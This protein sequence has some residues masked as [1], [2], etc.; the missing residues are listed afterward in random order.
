M[1]TYAM[2]GGATGIGAELRRQLQEEGHRVISV[3]IV[4][5][6]IIADLATLEGRRAAVDGVRELAPDGLDGFIPCAGLPPVAKPLSSIARVN[7]F[8]VVAT[9]EGLR[10]LLAK[11][12]GMVLF[13]SSNSAPMVSTGDSY[14][15][16]CLAGNEDNA[17]AEI[18]TRDGHTAYAGAKRA[19]TLWMRRHVVEYAAAGIR[20]NAVAPGIT[21]TPL[22]DRVFGDEEL[23]Q[24]M[25]QFGDSV[26]VGSPAQP[27]HIANVM[28]F[29]LSD[30]ASYVCGSVFFV[31]GGSDAMLRP[32]DF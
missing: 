23:G 27:F 14:V 28:R 10:E 8:A 4:E 16:Q 22:T 9:V 30:E 1:R 29:M 18:D 2:T 13:V 11:R 17:C 12:K 19:V 32:D 25:K 20:L 21:M 24:A 3:D 7:F 26:P 6:D 31:D 15:Q 5:G